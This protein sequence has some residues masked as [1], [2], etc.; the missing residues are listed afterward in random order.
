MCLPSL[1]VPSFSAFPPLFVLSSLGLQSSFITS[2]LLFFSL[3]GTY[4]LP[5]PILLW[6][7]ALLATQIK[8]GK[9][10]LYSGPRLWCKRKEKGDG[11]AA[12]RGGVVKVT[13]WRVVKFIGHK[14][15]CL[16]VFAYIVA[17]LS[18]LM[19]GMLTLSHKSKIHSYKRKSSTLIH[20][21]S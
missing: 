8:K 9:H 18:L 21:L 3:G 17:S 15:G 20:F 5:S 12:S 10:D 11:G 4:S 14:G 16:G 2:L 13:V 7:T 6:P 19:D 1:H